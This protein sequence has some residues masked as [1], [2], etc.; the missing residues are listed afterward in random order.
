MTLDLGCQVG[1]KI[2]KE[3]CGERVIQEGEEACSKSQW[4]IKVHTKAVSGVWEEH[5]RF[6]LAGPKC[7]PTEYEPL[8]PIHRVMLWIHLKGITDLIQ[9]ITTEPS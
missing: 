3:D 8:S 9:K 4:L 6:S 2:S 1:S 5:I 7:H